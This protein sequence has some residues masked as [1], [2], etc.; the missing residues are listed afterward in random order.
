VPNSKD[1]P[2]ELPPHIAE[3]IKSIVGFHAEHHGKASILERAV[4]RVTARIASPRFVAIVTVAVAAWIG[5]NLTLIA[6]GY[7][8]AD[9]PPFSW[10]NGALS[11]GSFYMVVFVLTTQRREDQLAQLREQV[12]LELVLLAEQKLAKVIELLEEARR[13]NPLLHDRVDGEAD[14]MARPADTKS[15]IH[16]IRETH[17]EAELI[18]GGPDAASRDVQ[19]G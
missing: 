5:L 14:A 11:L 3:T 9:P 13:D 16:S 17:A 7:Q 15:V 8:T 1:Q 18:A 6:L 4:A 10:L 12:T 2:P 19:P